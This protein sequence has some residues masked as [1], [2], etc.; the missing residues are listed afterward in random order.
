MVH[1]LLL[2][3]SC[4]WINKTSST[5]SDLSSHSPQESFL[6]AVTSSRDIHLYSIQHVP[7]LYESEGEGEDGDKLALL[8]F[9]QLSSMSKRQ[10]TNMLSKAQLG[11]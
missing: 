7:A 5:T 11:K 6:L 3:Y 2:F 8:P 4:V 10:I 9:K 1:W